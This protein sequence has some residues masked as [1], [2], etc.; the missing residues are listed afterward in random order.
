MTSL[1]TRILSF[2]PCSSGLQ[3]R[4]IPLRPLRLVTPPNS[5]VPHP[6][7]LPRRVGSYD[8]TPGA[9]S[10]FSEG[11]SWVLLLC[12]VPQGPVL[13]LGSWVSLL[14]ALCV[15]AFLWVFLA[16]VASTPHLRLVILSEAKDLNHCVLSPNSPFSL[17]PLCYLCGKFFSSLATP[18]PGPVRA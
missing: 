6:S 12:R 18:L 4:G 8:R 3:A 9:P 7:R 16:F 14:C 11:G 2:R 1:R 10:S 5:R 15:N 13:H 17:R